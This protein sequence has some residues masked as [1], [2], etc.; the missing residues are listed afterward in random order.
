MNM[1]MKK[2]GVI[3]FNIISIMMSLSLVV[4]VVY[5]G[6]EMYINSVRLE[7]IRVTNNLVLGLIDKCEEKDKTSILLKK[8]ELDNQF[9]NETNKFIWVLLVL[10]EEYKTKYLEI[11]KKRIDALVWDESLIRKNCLK[12]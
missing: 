7:D 1:N 9:I 4:W 11:L 5:C 12:N 2:V 6:T 10:D 3:W 8:I